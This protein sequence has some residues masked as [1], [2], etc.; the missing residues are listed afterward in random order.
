MMKLNGDFVPMPRHDE[1]S[2]V[3]W[4]FM[5]EASEQVVEQAFLV[6]SN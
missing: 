4:G 5:A 6:E 1:W 3:M 2:F